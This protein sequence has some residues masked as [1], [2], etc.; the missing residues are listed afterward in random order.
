M[1]RETRDLTDTYDFSR[2]NMSDGQR[3]HMA[4]LACAVI[5]DDSGGGIQH[6][7]ACRS[8]LSR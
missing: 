6:L 4:I 5:T 7:D 8:A 2:T 1:A 3:R